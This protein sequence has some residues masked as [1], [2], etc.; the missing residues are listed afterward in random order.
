MQETQFKRQGSSFL[1]SPG[2]IF[3]TNSYL[4]VGLTKEPGD[5]WLSGDTV[6]DSAQVKAACSGLGT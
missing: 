4:A 5:P 2:L 6:A 3:G 1:P